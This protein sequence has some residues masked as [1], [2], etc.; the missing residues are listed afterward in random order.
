MFSRAG[1]EL[2]KEIL[3]VPLHGALAY[4]GRC[5]NAPPASFNQL[6]LLIT[7]DS[8]LFAPDLEPDEAKANSSATSLD[9][10]AKAEHEGSPQQ[11]ETP[12]TRTPK[13]SWAWA[14]TSG[15]FD[16]MDWHTHPALTDLDL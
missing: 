3:E 12:A 4:C 8:I 14:E 13:A 5:P 10:V 1:V 9:P 2:S 16:W 15:H 7:M 11:V 6:N